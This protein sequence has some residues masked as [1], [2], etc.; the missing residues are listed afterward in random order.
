MSDTEFQTLGRLFRFLRLKLPANKVLLTILAVS[1]MIRFWMWPEMQFHHDELSALMRTRFTSFSELMTEGVWID[2]H[3]AFTQIFLWFWT[4]LIGYQPMVVKLPFI[5]SGIASVYLVYAISKLLFNAKSAYVAAS[6]MAVLQYSVV[7]SQWARPYAFGLFFMLGAFYFLIRFSND[8]R[9]VNLLGFAVL[10]SLSAYTHYFALLQ[11]IVFS[12]LWFVFRL[13]N[14]QR[15]WFLLAA[16]GAF[17]LWLPHLPVTLNHLAM[18]GIGYWLK[19]PADDY[20]LDLIGFSFHYS[21]FFALPF[22]VLALLY[23]TRST[24]HRST[25]I[26]QFMLIGS[27]IIPY[28]IAY[29]YSIEVSALMHFGTMVFTF[30]SLILL[31]GSVFINVDVSLSKMVALFV[32]VYGTV[33]LAQ[34]E[35]FQLNIKTEFQEPV[36]VF[37]SL[38]PHIVVSALFDLRA[39]AVMFMDEKGIEKMTDVQLIEPL[40]ENGRFSHYLD[41]LDTEFIFLV[42]HAGTPKEVLGQV[43]YRY[44]RVNEMFFYQSASAYL[45]SKAAANRADSAVK[46]SAVSEYSEPTTHSQAIDPSR[47]L[48]LASSH[49][50]GKRRNDA[51]LVVDWRSHS[52]ASLWQSADLAMFTAADSLQLT[53]MAFDLRDLPGYKEG[54]EFSAYVWNKSLDN[55]QIQKVVLKEFPSNPFR[56]GLFRR[57]TK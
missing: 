56:Y 17:I 33:T 5:L 46:W 55:I 1:A 51:K 41:H 11:L 36:E 9:K 28:V 8:S 12:A 25:L 14:T 50:K 42:V 38:D 37:R 26:T 30:P 24:L 7:Y 16:L 54:G 47:T 57:I 2:G 23:C 3:P 39:D 31:S 48:I 18:G 6:L 52:G 22:A 34:R 45:L 4:A 49:W 44:P 15:K 20:Y 43:L 40:L 32:L 13:N 27:W 29:F 19:T 21:W 10:T 35:H 53:A